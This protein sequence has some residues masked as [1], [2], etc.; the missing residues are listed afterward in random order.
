MAT[1]LIAMGII[2]AASA[3]VMGW[4]GFVIEYAHHNQ[5]GE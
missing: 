4:L 3:F 2:G 5:G 1:F